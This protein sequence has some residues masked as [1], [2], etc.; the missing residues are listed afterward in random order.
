MKKR[1]VILI[2]V[3]LLVFTLMPVGITAAPVDTRTLATINKPGVVL[4]YTTWTADVTWYEFAFDDS[5][6]ADLTAEIE[7][8]IEN[9]D[10]IK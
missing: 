3:F 1:L 4:I 9:G 2:L 6:D 8:M 5:L 7:L 10:R